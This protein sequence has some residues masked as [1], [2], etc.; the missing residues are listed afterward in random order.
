MD[1][2]AF[3]D[4]DMIES[5]SAIISGVTLSCFLIF[6]INK[7]IKKLVNGDGNGNGNSNGN[8]NG[9][10]NGKAKKQQ[11]KIYIPLRLVGL[12]EITVTENDEIKKYYAI[13]NYVNIRRNHIFSAYNYI[14]YVRKM[15]RDDFKFN[16]CTILRIS[17]DNGAHNE[18]YKSILEYVPD[19]TKPNVVSF[20]AFKVNHYYFKLVE[21]KKLID[22]F[23]DVF[24][25]VIF[26]YQH[27]AVD[28]L[29]VAE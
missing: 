10:G 12:F 22:I 29:K 2:L 3:I 13:A 7:V 21:N 24:P 19:N 26:Q 18:I 25:S 8:G 16:N 4:S 23:C 6:I 14:N 20:S 11:P 5:V 27:I 9:N 28:K 17:I 15:F 1:T